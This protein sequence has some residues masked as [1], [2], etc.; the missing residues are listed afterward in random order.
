MENRENAKRWQS[1]ISS[2]CAFEGCWPK[3]P[4]STFI[5]DGVRI[6][7]D[8]TFGENCSIWFNAVLRG[9]VNP[10]VIGAGT[11]IQDGALVHTTH[12]THTAS[13]GNNVTIGHL[14]VIHGCTIEDGC[15]IGMQ[16][17][18]MD[19]TVVGKNSLIG[20]GAVVTQGMKIPPRSLVLGAPAKIIRELTTEEVQSIEAS[21]KHYIEYT[22]GYNFT[23]T[24]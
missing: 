2:L 1:P 22:K 6:V 4:E 21:A 5:A 18:V 8:V 11:N 12:K 17:V 9:D 10:I 15:L 7:G 19:G 13:I 24:H 14:A 23:L 3:I 16:A 20:A